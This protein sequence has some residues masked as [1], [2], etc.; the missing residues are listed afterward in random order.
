MQFRESWNCAARLGTC[1]FHGLAWKTCNHWPFSCSYHRTAALTI[2]T[3]LLWSP[4]LPQLETIHASGTQTHLYGIW[5]KF[6][7]D[8]FLL[9]IG[10]T[11]DA[12]ILQNDSAKNDRTVL[13][14]NLSQKGSYSWVTATFFAL[15]FSL[16]MGLFNQTLRTYILLLF[17]S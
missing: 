10:S 5:D 15:Q 14:Y 8:Y 12:H 1:W 3:A 9:Y 13:Y 11:F 7:N 4:L 6:S 16:P 17:N 2:A